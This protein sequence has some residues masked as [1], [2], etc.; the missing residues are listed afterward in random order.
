MLVAMWAI[1]TVSAKGERQLMTV[2]AACDGATLATSLDFPRYDDRHP[3]QFPRLSIILRISP[4]KTG[5]YSLVE[6]SIASAKFCSAQDLC[7]SA[8]AAT[9]RVETL[10]K[11]NVKGHFT[12][13]FPSGKQES[14]AFDAKWYLLEDVPCR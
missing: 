5:N 7:D 11:R 6:H 1:P 10:S 13:T 8:T 9:V 2:T 14:K 4:L 3:S 12:L